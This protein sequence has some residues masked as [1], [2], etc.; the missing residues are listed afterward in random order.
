MAMSE[1]TKKKIGEA[2]RARAAAKKAEQSQKDIFVGVDR[3][4]D[5]G[6]GHYD[7]QPTETKGEESMS[8]EQKVSETTKIKELKLTFIVPPPMYKD[9]LTIDKNNNAKQIGLVSEITRKGDVFT[10]KSLSGASLNV[11]MFQVQY[12]VEE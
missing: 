7:L 11:P 5:K 9:H 8:A 6:R 4:N 12:F 2:T 3:T 10:I 1:E